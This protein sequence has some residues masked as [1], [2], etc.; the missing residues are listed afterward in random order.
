MHHSLV[1]G[2]RVLVR[3]ALPWQWMRR[4]ILSNSAFQPALHRW[5]IESRAP[6][7]K[8]GKT[9]AC[10]AAL[11]R[12]RKFISHVCVEVTVSLFSIVTTMRL[13]AICLFVWGMAE[14]T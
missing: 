6:A 3:M 1:K 2:E 9:C 8:Y 13:L 7:G 14:L 11:D 10:L 5:P 12:D 4:V